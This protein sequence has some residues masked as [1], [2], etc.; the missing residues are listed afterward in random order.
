[1]IVEDQLDRGAG[2]IGGVEKLEEFDE[3]ATAV[4]VLD[5]GVNRAGDEI[6]SSQ[7]AD[8]AVALIFHARVRRSHA[9][10]ARAAESG[11]VV[12]MAW[13]PGFSS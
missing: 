7:Q 10:R 6:D 11:A 4:A 12:A 2:W 5:E 3:F 9:R 13:I 8:R 1:M